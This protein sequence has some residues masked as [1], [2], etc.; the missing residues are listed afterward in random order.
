MEP[1]KTVFPS[2]PISA[3]KVPATEPGG[4]VETWGLLKNRPPQLPWRRAP[5][6]V[7]STGPWKRAGSRIR[8]PFNLACSEQRLPGGRVGAAC[9]D[10]RDKSLLEVS[11]QPHVGPEVTEHGCPFLRG[12]HAGGVASVSHPRRE[13]ADALGVERITAAGHRRDVWPPAVVGVVQVAEP[14]PHAQCDVVGVVLVLDVRKENGLVPSSGAVDHEIFDA[15]PVDQARHRGNGDT[16]TRHPGRSCRAAPDTGCGISVVEHQA[17]ALVSR[18]DGPVLADGSPAPSPVPRGLG[19]A[20][21]Q[22]SPSGP[23]HAWSHPWRL[24]GGPP[25]STPLAPPTPSPSGRGL[26]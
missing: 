18:P 20:G 10:A 24:H 26:G 11:R 3:P 4:A 19:H 21:I 25:T 8:T 9:E 22:W 16:V 5:S 23:F 7:P 6:V 15:L 1:L 17:G 2:F 12:I 13:S 14:K